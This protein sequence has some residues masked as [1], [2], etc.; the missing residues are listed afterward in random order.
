MTSNCKCNI[1]Y[2][3]QCHIYQ[4]IG[5]GGKMMH[6]DDKLM[7]IIGPYRKFPASLLA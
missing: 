5:A 2:A 7:G 1:S 4:G 6:G 3:Q